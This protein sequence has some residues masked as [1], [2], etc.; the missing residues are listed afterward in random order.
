VQYISE[1]SYDIIMLEKAKIT[2]KTDGIFDKCLNICSDIAGRITGGI[3]FS[4]SLTWFCLLLL[5][6]PFSVETVALVAAPIFGLSLL[7]PQSFLLRPM[8]LGPEYARGRMSMP[9]VVKAKSYEASLATLTAASLNRQIEEAL[10]KDTNIIIG[11]ETDWLSEVYGRVKIDKMIRSLKRRCKG[12]IRIVHSPQKELFTDVI[13]EANRS[14]NPDSKIVII[15]EMDTIKNEQFRW[16]MKKG[17]AFLAIDTK[18]LEKIKD[19][20]KNSKQKGI[21]VDLLEIL[22]VALKIIMEEGN[23]AIQNSKLQYD[24]QINPYFGVFMLQP[25]VLTTHQINKIYRTQLKIMKA[26]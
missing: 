19:L 20:L 5:G 10:S 3:S 22:E 23:I 8:S 24:P 21:Y 2:T 17:I 6:L 13:E 16:L 7:R 9:G 15:G 14:P 1:S 25:V 11:I 12:R 18:E 4:S 26:A